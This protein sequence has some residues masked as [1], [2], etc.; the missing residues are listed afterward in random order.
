ML[1]FRFAG[2]ALAA[3]VA[4][5]FAADAYAAASGTAVTAQ[6]V[7]VAGGET[8]VFTA[9]F[10]DA[11]GRPAAGETVRFANDACG[12]FPNNGYFVDVVADANGLAS[13]TFRAFNQ[14]ITCWLTASAG[15]AVRFDV[16]TYVAANAY[17]T[18]V[19]T[20]AQP[21]PGQSYT[22][23]VAAKYGQYMLYDADI[24][25][26]P[27]EGTASATI[28]PGRA[29][30]G[31]GGSVTF[32]VTPDARIGDYALEFQFRDRVQRLA[33]AAPASPWQD[34]WW[35]GI[36]ENGWGMSVVQH[37]ERLF[38]VI[39]AY[40][41]AGKPTWYV[42]S[43]GEWNIARTQYSGAL[44]SPRGAPFSAYDPARLEVGPPVGEATLAF[45]GGNDVTL[46]YSIGGTTGRKALTRQLF[47]PADTT[48]TAS[49]GDMWWG[50]ASQNGWGIALLQQYR[51]IFGV[52]FT[53]DAAGRPTWLV[54]PS[55]SWTG[56][57]TYEGRLY[58][59]SGAPWLSKAY[60]A[61]SFSTSDVGLFRLRFDT[62]AASFE[63]QVDGQ[64]G[65]IP[66]S[67][68]PF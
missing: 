34:L 32:T 61:R 8:Q 40:D 27:V 37:G 11:A 15:A 49:Y 35:A 28:S 30:S 10:L 57:S 58:R 41:D 46:D 45:A 51:T 66:L 39:Y 24:A 50:G 56:A 22:V 29:N 60:D 67:R 54:L 23:T 48:A 63:Y 44:Y 65:A 38:N 13:T 6:R 14:G 47:G 52:W 26:K 59:A 17:L 31:S 36:A 42:M 7:N 55:G 12:T 1:R 19:K 18:A 62:G 68:T 43:G 21:F 64:G 4:A 5:L 20:P 53:Y 2:G 33:I 9:R 3:A 25:A 16:L